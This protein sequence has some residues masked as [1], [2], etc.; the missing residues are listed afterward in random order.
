MENNT[1]AKKIST[2]IGKRIDA[3]I[4]ASPFSSL[5][6]RFIACKKLHF[7]SWR[8]SKFD[9]NASIYASECEH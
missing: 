8:L 1:K 5:K 9:K 4:T 7:L 6:K 2:M 3:S